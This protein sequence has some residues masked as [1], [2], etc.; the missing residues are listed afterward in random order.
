MVLTKSPMR[1]QVHLVLNWKNN[2]NNL[3]I[4]CHPNMIL[5]AIGCTSLC[6]LFQC[7]GRHDSFVCA[8][9]VVWLSRQLW[10][11]CICRTWL[12]HMRN[13]YARHDA[14]ICATSLIYMC[15]TT[16]ITQ[17]TTL[18]KL[19]CESYESCRTYEGVM[20]RIQMSHVLVMS[21]IWMSHVTHTNESCCAYE[22]VMSAY[23]W[24]MSAYEWVMSAYE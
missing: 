19:S 9:W 8:T 17:K 11:S 12:I 3:E 1:I 6:L 23:E 14:F 4:L 10:Q 22:W 7:D 5:S 24:V 15:N 20:L 21:R 2:R 16:R 13:T 18:S